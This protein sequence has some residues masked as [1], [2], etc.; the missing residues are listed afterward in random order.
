[1]RQNQLLERMENFF[2]HQ[3]NMQETEKK[4]IKNQDISEEIL[5]NFLEQILLKFS[6]KIHKNFILEQE[7]Q[8]FDPKKHES[9]GKQDNEEQI[10]HEGYAVESKEDEPVLEKQ[11]SCNCLPNI[12]FEHNYLQPAVTKEFDPPLEVD[13]YNAQVYSFARFMMLKHTNQYLVSIFRHELNCKSNGCFHVIEGDVKKTSISVHR[14]KAVFFIT[15]PQISIADFSQ[16]MAPSFEN[17]PFNAETVVNFIVTFSSDLADLFVSQQL[18]YFKALY[19]VDKLIKLIIVEF[20]TTNGA[21]RDKLQKS[22]IP[23]SYKALAQ[24]FSRVK[25]LN[26]GTTLVPL[27]PS[28]IVFFLDVDMVFTTRLAAS[29][30]N[31]CVEG[32]RIYFPVRMKERKVGGL[33]VLPEGLGDVGMYRSDAEKLP[34]EKVDDTVWGGEDDAMLQNVKHLN[35]DFYRNIEPGFIH[36]YHPDRKAGNL[37]PLLLL[38]K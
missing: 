9:N 1:M 24:P 8:N 37:R 26:T 5:D 28:Q 31:R 6:E 35:Y 10:L 4:F 25:G 20:R 16:R 11:T 29:I 18:P 22:G 32:R 7:A 2:A 30:R 38:L 14:T 36:K 12:V 33:D 3:Y 34:W 17:Y 23:F 21:I 27:T 15:E 19:D 13:A